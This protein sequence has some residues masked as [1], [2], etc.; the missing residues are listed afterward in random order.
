MQEPQ[1][2]DQS[3]YLRRMVAITIK[4]DPKA[5]VLFQVREN[6]PDHEMYS[7]WEGYFVALDGLVV[8]LSVTKVN[9]AVQH[10]TGT[11]IRVPY[12]GILPLPPTQE[13]ALV[14][15]CDP[16]K[17]MG[18]ETWWVKQFGVENCVI[19]PNSRAKSLTW[20]VPTWLLARVVP[21]R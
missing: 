4:N 2:L 20:S 17:P 15:V 16:S 9:G 21:K 12:Q 19:C 8:S 18:G 7:G 3:H 11:I 5:K 14:V 6:V 1:E 13:K 10:S